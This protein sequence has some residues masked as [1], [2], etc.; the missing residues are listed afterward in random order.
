M[1]LPVKPVP[2]K[3]SC[4]ELRNPSDHYNASFLLYNKVNSL[5]VP[6]LMYWS[7]IF[8]Q[9]SIDIGTEVKYQNK[10]LDEMVS[11]HFQFTG[12]RLRHKCAPEDRKWDALIRLNLGQ[13][14]SDKYIFESGSYYLL[15]TN[16]TPKNGKMSMSVVQR[17]SWRIKQQIVYFI[18]MDHVEQYI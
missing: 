18:L 13:Y 12:Q 5:I 17:Y 6:F 3:W 11:F 1:S 10:M 9:L 16:K 7:V 15:G 2:F 4:F 8:F 14:Y